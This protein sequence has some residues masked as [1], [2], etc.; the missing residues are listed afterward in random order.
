VFP[1]ASARSMLRVREPLTWSYPIIGTIVG[2]P[3]AA[4]STEEQCRA[5]YP[6]CHFDAY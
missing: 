6:R 2:G 3:I 1:A 4:V 5:R